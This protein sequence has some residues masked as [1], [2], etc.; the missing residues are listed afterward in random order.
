VLDRRISRQHANREVL[1]DILDPTALADR[2]EPESH[3]F[4]KAFSGYLCRVL[5]SFKIADGDAAAADRIGGGVA[6]DQL[7]VQSQLGQI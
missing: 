4:V 5:D 3:S 6:S 2:P 7:R 1:A